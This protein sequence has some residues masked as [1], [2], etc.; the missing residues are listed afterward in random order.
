MRRL[1]S[2]LLTNFGKIFA[3]SL[4]AFAGLYLLIEFFERVDDFT[5]NDAPFA[6]YLGYFGGKLPL[7]IVEIMPLALLLAVFLSLGGLSRHNELTAMLAG[8]ISF[9]RITLPLIAFGLVAAIGLLCWDNWIVPA[10]T[11]LSNEILEV[12]VR[13]NP[14]WS[15]LQNDI[16]LRD[17]Q[18]LLFISQAYPGE[19]RLDGITL[20]ELGPTGEPQRRIDANTARFDGTAWM[21]EDLR[22]F[23]FVEGTAEVRA[24]REFSTALAIEKHPEDFA[25]GEPGRH[26]SSLVDQVCL[27]RNLHRSG[28]STARVAVDLQARFAHGATC[29]VMVFLGL[30]FALQRQRGGNLALGIG[31]SVGLGIGFYICNSTLLAFGYGGAL[32]P[33]VAAWATNFAFAAL[34]GYLLLSVRE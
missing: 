21:G 15:L 29:I 25:R 32:P 6:Y 28:L 31:L 24:R 23:E 10:A 5:R 26:Q 20:L 12:K 11:R 30:P 33:V 1:D 7:I 3:L 27:Y 4:A 14:S 34:G 13:G 17:R 16:W 9:V 8:G 2:Y 19:A 22:I 18:N